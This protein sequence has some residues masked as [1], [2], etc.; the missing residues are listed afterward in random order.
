M[1]LYIFSNAVYIS[2]V[3]PPIIYRYIVPKFQIILYIVKTNL[4]IV[5]LYIHQSFNTFYIYFKRVSIHFI[6]VLY[7]F[8]SHFTGSP[9]VGQI[10]FRVS[11]PQCCA[12]CN[13][14]NINFRSGYWSPGAYSCVTTAILPKIK[15]QRY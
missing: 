6:F 5:Y 8:P 14:D 10:I 4:L 9:S 2:Y 7:E 13:I 3:L 1:A 12:H 15:Y 11:F